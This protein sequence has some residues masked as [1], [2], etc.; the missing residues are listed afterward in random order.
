MKTDYVTKTIAVYNKIAQDYAQKTDAYAP[1]PERDAFIVKLPRGGKILDAGCG[2]GRDSEYFVRKGFSLV[3]IDL[4]EKLL[5]IAKKRVTLA[6]FQK[7]DLRKLTFAPEE[8]DGIW[9]S[10]SLLHLKRDEIPKVLRQFYQI[11]KRN[12]A[13]FILVK[14]GTREGFIPYKLASNLPRFFSYFK[15]E[16]IK[17]VL[18]QVGFVIENI[19]SWDQKDRWPERPSEVWIS[20]F[21]KKR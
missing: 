11:L 3:G 17:R 19:Y 16:E 2:P 7:Q 13:L 4:S 21:S 9:A 8:F 18:E 10:A 15:S 1:L 5:S 12:G 20:S 14:E 6:T